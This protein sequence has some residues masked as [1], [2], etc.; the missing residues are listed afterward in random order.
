MK[1][2]L[3]TAIILLFLSTQSS[4]AG[5]LTEEQIRVDGI[6]RA[7]ASTVKIE[8]LGT[9]GLVPLSSGS[10]FFVA[11]KLV[12]TNYHVAMTPGMVSVRVI[13]SD[14]R[15]C[16][17]KPGY[18]DNGVDLALVATDCSAP[19]LAIAGGAEVGQDVYVI[20]SSALDFAVSAGI[21]AKLDQKRHLVANVFADRGNSGGPMVNGKGEVIG[22]VRGKDGPQWFVYGIQINYIRNF[23]E[24]AGIR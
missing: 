21:V 19:A 14:G 23:L 13:M 7:L 8:V 22:V 16:A 18:Q 6:E 2:V 20:G 4:V 1:A 11:D 15:R 12:L 10:G 9:D 24:R 17:G 5:S 3:L